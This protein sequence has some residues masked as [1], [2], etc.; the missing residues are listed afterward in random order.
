M[1]SDDEVIC[2]GSKPIKY[3][4]CIARMEMFRIWSDV[5]EKYSDKEYFSFCVFVNRLRAR[6]ALPC[7]THFDYF[8]G[9]ALFLE[10]L[11]KADMVPNRRHEY[12]RPA[13][14]ESVDF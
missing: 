14:G 6:K 8:W 12:F 10:E 4:W 1:S 11:R 9:A 13:P 7:A 5:Q 2:F 3:R